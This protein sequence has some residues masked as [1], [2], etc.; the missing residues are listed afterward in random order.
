MENSLFVSDASS[1][2]QQPGTGPPVSQHTREKA[3]AKVDTSRWPAEEQRLYRSFCKDVE[4]AEKETAHRSTEGSMRRLRGEDEGLSATYEKCLSIARK[5]MGHWIVV[6]WQ[7]FLETGR[8][9]Q[10]QRL[11]NAPHDAPQCQ[12]SRISADQLDLSGLAR[13][14]K[15]LF[16]EAGAAER[17][18]WLSHFRYR[19]AT[20][21]L[22][23]ICDGYA[24]R[25][26]KRPVEGATL[27]S[28]DAS[29]RMRALFRH[30]DRRH[31]DRLPLAPTSTD[32]YS[33]DLGKEWDKLNSLIKDGRRWLVLSQHLGGLGALLLI[34]TTNRKRYLERDLPLPVFTA[35]VKLVA[36]V[37]LNIQE[38]AT[39]MEYYHD[40][41]ETPEH[42]RRNLAP[43]KMERPPSRLTS[44]STRFDLDHDAEVPW[45]EKPLSIDPNRPSAVWTRD[46]YDPE[47]DLFGIAP[48]RTDE[49]LMREMLDRYQDNVVH[50]PGTEGD[51]DGD[52]HGGV[53]NS[54]FL[55]VQIGL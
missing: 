19:R 17:D 28:R 44:P 38:V 8:Q 30:M 29:M 6:Q 1:Y 51:M 33:A 39:R 22:A 10:Q 24:T 25:G 16:D 37:R 52:L 18:E 11:R 45:T 15:R 41:L 40:T 23:R 7:S 26:N 20:I 50:N 42:Y 31:A 32:I 54:R 47:E 2:A 3:R 53:S 49:D 48:S 14:A 55:D 5:V 46:E 9:R 27:N 21:G 12:W 13:N 43:L 34:D 36:K 35:W 4:E